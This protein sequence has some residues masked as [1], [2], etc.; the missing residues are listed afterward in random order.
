MVRVLKCVRGVILTQSYQN[1][2]LHVHERKEMFLELKI[3][4]VKLVK[5]ELSSFKVLSN[6]VVFI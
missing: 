3:T 6:F 5:V 2:S 1:E 4:I